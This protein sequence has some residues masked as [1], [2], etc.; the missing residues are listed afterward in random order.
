M[1]VSNIRMDRFSTIIYKM[2]SI[3]VRVWNRE[4]A[5][6][7][8]MTLSLEAQS[9]IRMVRRMLV[10]PVSVLEGFFSIFFSFT[11]SL[12]YRASMHSMFSNSEREG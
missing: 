4:P 9:E 10:Q 8:Y 11:F 2:G 6:L 1:N 5:V 3:Y 12:F 7:G